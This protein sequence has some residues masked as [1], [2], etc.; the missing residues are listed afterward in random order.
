MDNKILII[1]DDWKLRNAIK[2][3]FEDESYI[4][5]EAS[6]VAEG[7]ATIDEHPDVQVVILDLDFPGDNGI[8]FLEY[9]ESQPGQHRVIIL[10]AHDELLAAEKANKY[11][12]FSYQPK[13]DRLGNQSLK[14]EIW[15]AFKDI[16]EEFL[17]KKI[18][19]H[20]DVQKAI[21]TKR[22][23][24]DT[25]NIICQHLLSLIDAYTCHIRVF[26]L[27]K[28]DFELVGYHGQLPE[29][30][31]IFQARRASGDF[32]SG[33][34]AQSKTPKIVDNLQS[35]PPFIS[36]KEKHLST[37]NANKI[38][39]E[40]IK[41]VQSAYIS[42]IFT[43]ISTRKVD[44][45]LNISSKIDGYFSDPFI[46]NS[47]EEFADQISLAITK[48]W[49]NKN[50]AEIHLGYKDISGMLSEV[51]S[52]LKEEYQLDPIYD[53]L[54][55]RIS[56]YIKP[57]TLSIF[58]YNK[59]TELLE[60]I[61]EY[62]EDGHSIKV[63]EYYRKGENVTG[64]AFQDG[65]S[66]RL[67][68]PS[69]HPKFIKYVGRNY[70]QVEQE[71][72]LCAP[73]KIG[74][75]NIGIIRA[76]NKKAEGYH[77]KNINTN[78]KLLDRG[79][80][81]EDQAF[82]EI[83]AMHLAVAIKN[84]ISHRESRQW[85]KKLT[86]LN[87]IMQ[88]MT[89]MRSVDDLLE[90]ILEQIKQ[91]IDFKYG[92]ITKVDL[93]NGEQYF[94]NIHGGKP[95][96]H[97]LPLWQGITGEALKDKQPKRV[98]NVKSENWKKLYKERWPDTR[99]ELAV[100]IFVE[101]APVR[102]RNEIHFKTKL[103][104]VINLEN[105]KPGSFTK[106]DEDILVLLARHATI[107]IERLEYDTKTASLKQMERDIARKQ[108]WDEIIE[109][110]ANAI[111]KTLGYGYVNISMVDR[112]RNRIK[113]QY[114]NGIPEEEIPLFKE[115]ADHSLK[116][117]DIQAHIVRNKEIEVPDSDDSRF[118]SK[119]VNR[120]DHH[121]LLRVFIPMITTSENQIIGTVE[122]GYNKE[123]R[124][125]I[126]E[127]DIEILRNFI[128]YAVQALERKKKG[129]LDQLSH[130][131]MAPINGIRSNASFLKR[132]YKEI[133][134]NLVQIKLN[135]IMT[136]S[137]LLLYQ[138]QELEYI[139]GRTPPASKREKTF[140]FRDVVI[141]IVN[142]LT[143][144]LL[145]AR[146]NVDNIKYNFTDIFTIAPLYIDKSKINQVVYNLLI[147]AIK[148][149]KED[150]KKFKIQI[151]AGKTNDAFILKFADWGIGIRKGDEEKIFEDGFRTHDATRRHVSGSG[152]G[153]TISRKIMHEL[154]GDLKLT[155]NESP[156]EFQVIL[157]MKLKEWPDDTIH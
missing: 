102:I 5:L 99:S 117:K 96:Y 67:L 22:N 32:Y 4:F 41:D 30:D 156:T 60:N 120:F 112:E 88:K 42:P 105:P 7:I 110:V 66:L 135:D 98:D 106:S 47:V 58:L 87:E 6:S 126:Y 31:A 9:I 77:S 71:H 132:R 21:N 155:G 27:K 108:D 68:D 65:K 56:S 49:L 137:E 154:G 118:D 64:S 70:P 80:S 90:L 114:I 150:R 73:M 44:A 149:A 109:I 45:I 75:E 122:A 130:E 57:E 33:M 2:L 43:A 134:N 25:L 51:S 37:K 124:K 55:K 116:S 11:K 12:V 153:L 140:L 13:M 15:K 103:I 131:F 46:R 121:N 38:V 129:L 69:R 152:L 14:F 127:K 17:K 52:E 95:K 94:V 59:K 53:I 144:I 61:V 128:N 82:L 35:D 100:P 40:Y 39:V 23:L 86:K 62:R 50:K 78:R 3:S 146:L 34:V 148:Y 36:F 74:E 54:Y 63:T 18:N 119:I 107:M 28:G 24:K 26:D 145:E 104:G 147:N 143:P 123:F 20:L 97:S 138:V 76:I 139:L 111:T 10:T 151:S 84:A 133:N 16:E 93:A 81:E 1:E 72:Y 141:K 115:M 79:F 101:N 8:K 142:Q 136:D 92:L 89:E 85:I 157:P 113:T 48:H 91:L 29:A 19:A 83:A 125:Y